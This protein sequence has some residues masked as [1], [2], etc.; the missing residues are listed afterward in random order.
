[1]WQRVEVRTVSRTGETIEEHPARSQTLNGP[2]VVSVSN[3][4]VLSICCAET[5][6]LARCGPSGTLIIEAIF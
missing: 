4:L 2:R 3:Y 5:W 1:V 6:S